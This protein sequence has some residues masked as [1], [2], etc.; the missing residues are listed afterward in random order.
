MLKYFYALSDIVL[1]SL[2]LSR[3]RPTTGRSCKKV[4]F[5]LWAVISF[6][7]RPAETSWSQK[8][9]IARHEPNSQI[10]FETQNCRHHFVVDDDDDEKR[11]SI[12]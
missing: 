10:V 4:F 7:R 5:F 1:H 12:L 2:S 9:E 6:R 11:G 8:V 3:R